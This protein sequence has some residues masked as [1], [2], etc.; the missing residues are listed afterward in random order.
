MQLKQMMDIVVKP[1]FMRQPGSLTTQPT[2][3]SVHKY[4]IREQRSNRMMSKFYLSV[5]AKM[6][7]IDCCLSK[8]YVLLKTPYISSNTMSCKTVGCNK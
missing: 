8:R 4:L 7:A 5:G 1:E 3:L 6:T 2:D